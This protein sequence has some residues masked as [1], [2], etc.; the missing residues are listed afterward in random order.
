VSSTAIP[1]VV[2]HGTTGILVPPLDPGA[3]SD[4]VNRLLDSPGERERLGKNAREWAEANLDWSVIA[5]EYET[6]L[7]NAA[8]CS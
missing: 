5:G 2:A 4:E 7:Q 1:E 8:R 3:L 6:V